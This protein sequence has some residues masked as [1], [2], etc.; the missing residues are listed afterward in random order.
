MKIIYEYKQ[1]AYGCV[2]DGNTDI[3]L[4]EVGKGEMDWIDLLRDRDRWRAF[5]KSVMNFRVP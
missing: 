3:D 2:W 1:T 4:L 5:V